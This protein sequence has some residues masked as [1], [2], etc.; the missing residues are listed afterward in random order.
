MRF[1]SVSSVILY[2]CDPAHKPAKVVTSRSHH[3]LSQTDISF[4]PSEIVEKRFEGERSGME[5]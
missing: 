3:R 1:P 2:F 4:S 5:A